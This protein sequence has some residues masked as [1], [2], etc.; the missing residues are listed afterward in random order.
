MI[1]SASLNPQPF[2]RWIAGGLFALVY[3]AAFALV[4]SP[5]S[6]LAVLPG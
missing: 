1:R 5:G 3:L 2:K 4:V 6:V